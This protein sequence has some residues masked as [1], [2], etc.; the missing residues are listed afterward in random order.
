M[1]KTGVL[2][3]NLG[4]P[5]SPK[6]KDVYKYLKQ[7]L[8]DPRVID[9]PAIPRNLLVRGIIVPFR[10]RSSA[11]LYQQ[12]WTDEGSPIKVYGQIL[13][14]KVQHSL[15]DEYHTVLAMR[16]QSPSIESGV[17]EL[18]QAAV[19][20]IIVLPLFPQYASATTGSVHDEV[21]RIYRERQVIPE[22][23]FINSYYDNEEMIDVFARHAQQYDIDSYDHILFSYHGLPQRQLAKAD[24]FNHCLKVDNCC[25]QIT[26]KN[27]FC[28]SA[29]CHGTTH[30]IAKKL[31]L[32]Q[33]QYTVCFQ[34]RLGR[35]VWTQPYASEIIEKR[36]QLGD[37]K[38][39]VF[40]PAFVADC[41]ET[42]I[43]IGHEYLEEFQEF[44]GE[45][46]DLVESLNDDPQWVSAV[47][48]MIQKANTGKVVEA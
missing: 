32:S 26:D 18:M 47:V 37:K 40:S 19:D 39:L 35:E 46:L 14:D 28:Y 3:V 10:H 21:M 30:A 12:L 17:E 29:Q 48:N 9:Y 25:Q 42:T 15:G 33:D 23:T 36:A 34:S 4:T 6:P 20:R 24:I 16:Y 41:L 2:L 44:G 13:R 5:D 43:E 45:S 27:K 7:F 31:G 38:L 8:L 11:K 1:G 22:L